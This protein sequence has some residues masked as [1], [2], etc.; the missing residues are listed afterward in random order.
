MILGAFY[1]V[2]VVPVLK[3]VEQ[4]DYP[5]GPTRTVDKGS[6]LQ[7][8][9]LGPYMS[10]LTLSQHVHFTKLGIHHHDNISHVL[11]HQV[12]PSHLLHGK[13]LAGFLLPDQGYYAERA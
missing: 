12:L 6:C 11:E 5:L 4:L 1:Q 7:D 9:A 8:V 3:T 13:Q 2:Q 10:L